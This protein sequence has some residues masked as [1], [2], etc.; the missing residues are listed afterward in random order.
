MAKVGISSVQPGQ[1]SEITQAAA[2]S[3]TAKL[4]EQTPQAAPVE[5]GGFESLL[6]GAAGSPEAA[7]NVDAGISA[8]LDVEAQRESQR[9]QPLGDRLRDTNRVDKWKLVQSKSE[10]TADSGIW[11]RA[12]NVSKKV[13]AGNIK[14]GVKPV[15]EGFKAAQEAT[16]DNL[17]ST[18]INTAAEGSVIGA[19][20]RAGAVINEKT[21]TGNI[22][23]TV[24]PK[25]I[26]MG[27]LV[28]ENLFIDTAYG[29]EEGAPSPLDEALGEEAAAN[30]GTGNVSKAKNNTK[31]GHEIHREYMRWKNQSE[32][33]PSDE[34]QDLPASEATTLGDAFKELYYEANK[35]TDGQKLMNRVLDPETGQVYF[36]F[37]KLG[38]AQLSKGDQ[39]RKRMF[40]KQQVRATK[41]ASPTGQLVG[42]QGKYRKGASGLVGKVGGTR[43]LDEA[44]KN[45]ASVPNVVDKQRLKILFTTILPVLSG[46]LDHNHVYAAIN[47][48]GVK[49]FAKFRR[50]E[51]DAFKEGKE[52]DTAEEALANLQESIA[53]S[54]L[55]IAQE[56][57]GANYLT[58]YLQA[59][60]GRIAPQQSLF[61]PTSSK[62]VRFVTRNATP[63][64]A[65]PGS[66]VENNLRQM[67]AMMLV[68]GADA[69]LPKHR[70]IA[71][72]KN[73]RQ[74][75][76]WGDK[77]QQVLNDTTTDE[78][79]EAAAAAIEKG[80][81][82]TDPNFP[83]V[84]PLALD[85]Q[86][87]ADLLALI[88]K[89]GE[90]G[91]HFI[92]GL[93]DFAKYI[94]AKRAGRPYPS[95]FNAYIDG[96]TNGIASNGIQLGSS[97]IA[98]ATG[99]VRDN[100]KQLLDAGDIRDHLKTSLIASLDQGFDG[101][102][103]DIAGPLHD[104]A[105]AVYSYR[106]LNKATTMTF[107][108]GKEISSFGG[109]IKN[110]MNDLYQIA[111]SGDTDAIAELGLDTY[112][113][114]Y[115]ALLG[116]DSKIDDAKLSETL[117][118]K[119][120]TSLE[121]VL[122]S[123]ALEARALMRSAAVL[124]AVTNKLFSIKSP[125][126]L[127]LNMGG[128]E[129]IGF[130]EETAGSYNITR[131]GKDRHEDIAVGRQDV[132][133]TSAAVRPRTD[134]EGNPT[135]D[136]GGYAYGGSIPG[137]VQS[138]DAAT[139]G[140]TVSGRSWDKLVNASNGNPYIHSIYDAFKM[141]AN[142][143]DVILNETNQNWLDS[144]MK[145][146]YLEQTYE[147]T[148]NM[149]QNFNKE[150]NALDPSQ[151][152]DVSDE[153]PYRMMGD[154]L[155]PRASQ[156]GKF[157]SNLMKKMFG[158]IPRDKDKYTQE[159]YN[160]IIFDKTAGIWNKMQKSGYKGTDGKATAAQLKLFVQLLTKELDLSSGLTK[161]INK[162]NKQKAELAKEIKKSGPVLQYYAH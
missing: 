92:D 13:E 8:G 122:S 33:K 10:E 64:M 148:K 70:E 44:M 51:Q 22:T 161:M 16:P 112:A 68:K 142:G 90:D 9:V 54:V 145:W 81:S 127:D 28:T 124:H 32:G 162:T 86:A 47:N 11:A 27:A 30:V 12:Q 40:P 116:E 75:E 74:L 101:A 52:A 151:E 3:P 113:A 77:L 130:D 87:D 83:K 160:K 105:Q 17:T 96:K 80:V 97:K 66:R 153:G 41:S 36:N 136:I 53:Q 57:N 159:Q 35:G 37:T 29:K 38:E 88:K 39:I 5:L 114:S 48:M 42:E 100:N 104:V 14:L 69:L 119:Y 21:A 20:N 109:N 59:F 24:D 50:T 63:A 138:I 108:Y 76:A 121:N 45:L 23:S 43:L 140:K 60:N 7:A 128:L 135:K 18:I 125:V 31:L 71:L 99:V 93:I 107:G 2:G 65:T 144:S 4:Q 98:Q 111:L 62:A 103:D 110:T 78:H 46:E 132:E 147:S 102:T 126:G 55:G 67:Y 143:Y 115:D 137:P 158:L 73:E 118:T 106:D 91:P 95:Y 133:A 72:Q 56:R 58:Y 157:P 120:A 26:Q 155:D 141:D 134:K 82:L 117:L 146:S 89:K 152:L 1:E 149:M 49:Q 19:I 61:D 156:S 34:Y 150:I 15:K 154:L 129:A 94:K 25:Y 139:V 79:I 131:E 84:P 85:P 6:P 123:D